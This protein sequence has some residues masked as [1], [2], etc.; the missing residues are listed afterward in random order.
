[1]FVAL[2]QGGRIVLG[3]KYVS[4]RDSRG[5]ECRV[6]DRAHFLPQ[7]LRDMTIE[8]ALSTAAYL[9]K[10][11]L[12]DLRNRQDLTTRMQE[13]MAEW[14][15]TNRNERAASNLTIMQRHLTKAIMQREF[16]GL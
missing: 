1:M 2:D 11:T 5:R 7:D 4:A 9:A 6:L 13:R 10:K 8:Q 16:A 15:K 14:P 3:D 12:R